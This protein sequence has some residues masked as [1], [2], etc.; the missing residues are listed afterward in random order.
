M[1]RKDP[2][3]FVLVFLCLG[4]VLGC[5]TTQAVDTKKKAEAKHQLGNSLLY[6]KNYQGAVTE[7]REAAE[8]DPE[9]A[10]IHNSLGLAYQGLRLPDRA[11]PHYQK[12]LQIKPNFPEFENNLGTA[13]AAARQWDLAIQYFQKAADNYLYRTRHVGY[14]NLGSAYHNKG[15]FK[16]A[17]ENY[18]KAIEYYKDYTPAYINM[19]ISYEA[20]NDWD[21]AIGAY[22][23]AGEIEPDSA[24]PYL[25]LGDLYLRLGHQEAAVE[26][27]LIA[28]RNDPNGPY[29]KAARS[30]LANTRKPK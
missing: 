18:R 30:L 27:L 12:A 28:I 11:I 7:L 4:L 23:K 20:L 1:M 8:L 17:I 9:N 21:K 15:D 6:E 22:K 26:S 16:R 24:L 10:N 25:Q 13:Y 14:E 29:G 5:A 19:G 3:F 2:G